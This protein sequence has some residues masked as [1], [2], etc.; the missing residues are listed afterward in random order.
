M[1]VTEQYADSR[2]SARNALS[3][4]ESVLNSVSDAIASAKTL[5]IRP[6]ATP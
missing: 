5:M 4:E 3:Q 2:V 1:S 6:P